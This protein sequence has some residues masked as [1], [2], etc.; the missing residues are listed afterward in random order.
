MIAVQLLFYLTYIPLLRRCRVPVKSAS[1]DR[2]LVSSSDPSL[3]D[4]GSRARQLL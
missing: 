3:S 1:P 2:G 4:R